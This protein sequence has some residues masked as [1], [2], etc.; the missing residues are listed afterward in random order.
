[1]SDKLL[2]AYKFH[3]HTTFTHWRTP[4]FRGYFFFSWCYLY[5]TFFNFNF[6]LAVC[7]QLLCFHTIKINNLKMCALTTESILAISLMSLQRPCSFNWN[8][9]SQRK[10]K[11][12]LLFE[13]ILVGEM[14]WE[15]PSGR[16]HISKPCKKW[17][18]LTDIYK[19]S[20]FKQEKK[21]FQGCVLQVMV[22]AVNTTMHLSEPLKYN[23]TNKYQVSGIIF[24]E[25]CSLPL[26]QID[27]QQEKVLLGYKRLWM[28]TYCQGW[29]KM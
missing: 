8:Y 22:T 4:L 27:W 7:P 10:L 1:M 11:I 9:P 16:G 25:Q 17:E 6:S 29:H 28:Y 23:R 14:M 15:P 3:F 5:D 12:P 26:I 21:T 20:G 2:A 13:I 19:N 18:Q 24:H